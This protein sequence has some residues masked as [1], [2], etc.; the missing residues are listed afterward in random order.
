MNNL[1]LLIICFVAGIYSS[2]HPTAA[3]I[4][5]RIVQFPL[6]IVLLVACC[7][8]LHVVPDQ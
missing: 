5:R 8:E 7:G 4:V 6:F 1:V 3:Q 2:G